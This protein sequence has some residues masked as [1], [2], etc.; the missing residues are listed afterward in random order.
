MK[1]SYPTELWL[2][3]INAYR[4][5][6]LSIMEHIIIFRGPHWLCPAAALASTRLSSE[7]GYT[8]THTQ[9]PSPHTGAAPHNIYVS[10]KVAYC[11]NPL[12]SCFLFTCPLATYNIEVAYCGNPQYNCFL[13]T[14]PQ[15]LR[16]FDCLLFDGRR[17]CGLYT[18]NTSIPMS[19]Y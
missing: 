17:A 6:L 4:Y 10:I 5:F 19:A 14:R 2:R 13:F 1:L 7:Y 18:Q 16:H 11:G 3:S 9:F 15:E 8:V 12:Y